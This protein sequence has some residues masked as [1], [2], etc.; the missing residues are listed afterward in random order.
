MTAAL[1][2]EFITNLPHLFEP[3]ALN[4]IRATWFVR[5]HVGTPNYLRPCGESIGP[6]VSS[7]LPK[8]A[9]LVGVKPVITLGGLFS[10]AVAYPLDQC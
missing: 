1:A 6:K 3:V 7:R 9:R 4:A 10:F 2:T 5:C 8:K